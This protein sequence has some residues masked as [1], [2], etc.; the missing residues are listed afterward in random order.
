MGP[1]S[2]SSYCVGSSGFHPEQ[3]IQDSE[4]QRQALELLAQDDFQGASRALLQLPDPDPYTYHAM[5]SI[6]LA[7]VQRVVGLGGVNGLHAWYRN[8]DKSPVRWNEH[9]FE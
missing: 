1:P 5:T 6:K 4:R 3:L 8:E 7:E 2:K 9:F